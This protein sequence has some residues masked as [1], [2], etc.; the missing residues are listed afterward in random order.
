[1]FEA[2]RLKLLGHIVS[3]KGLEPDPDKVAAILAL[4]KPTNKE[5][6]QRLLGTITYLGKYIPNMS[7]LT[8]SIRELTHK[9][10]IKWEADHDESFNKMKKILT[11]QPVLRLFDVRKP[12]TLS[13]DASSRNLGAALLQDG[14]LV[15]CG[16]RALTKS[17]RNYP[18]IEKEALVIHVKSFI[19]MFMAKI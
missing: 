15:A 7:E 19:S 14:Q 10:M 11:S 13:V 12:V 8:D 1:M 16:V 5:E 2:K 9:D 3:A 4:K 17:E 18:Q 6:V